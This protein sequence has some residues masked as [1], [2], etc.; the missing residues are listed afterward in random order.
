MNRLN[1]DDLFYVAT[2]MEYTA[3][4]TNNEISYIA[5]IPDVAYII[6]GCIFWGHGTL[7]KKNDTA[8]LYF[9]CSLTAIYVLK[10]I[11][12]MMPMFIA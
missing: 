10:Y 9:D 1:D 3:R 2:I 11:T 7:Y 5:D 12:N 4:T 8:L 6:C